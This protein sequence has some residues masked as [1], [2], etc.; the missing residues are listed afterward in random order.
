LYVAFK[1]FDPKNISSLKD[2]YLL[3]WTTTPWTLV[4]NQAVSVNPHFTYLL[5]QSQGK[6]YVI[7][8]DLQPKLVEELNWKN[9]QVLAT[10]KGSELEFLTYEHP[11]FKNPLPIINGEHVSNTEGSGLVHTAPGHG[12][13]DYQVGL[14][15]N[16]RV[17]CPVDGKG[18]YT[19]EARQYQGLFYEKANEI[20]INDLIKADLLVKQSKFTHSYPHDWRTKKPVI[21]RATPQWFCSI[22]GLKEQ[23]LKNIEE[24]KWYPAWGQIRMQNMIKDRSD[25]CI[26]RQRV[27]GV[28]LPIFYAEDGSPILDEQIILHISKKFKKYGSDC[29]FSKTPKQLLPKGYTHPASPHG[30]FTKETDIMDVW[31]DSG[32]SYMVVKNQGFFPANLYLEGADQFRGWFNSSLIT[33][34]SVYGIS[35]YRE[36]VTHGFV[37]DGAGRKMS[38]SLGN[39]IN[40]LDVINKYGADVLR[41][42]VSTTEYSVDVRISNDI[43]DQVAEIYRKIRNTL[44][45]LLGAINDFQVDKSFIAYSMQNSVNRYILERLD[46]VYTQ[47]LNAYE[48]YNFSDVLKILMPFI[49]NEL[50][51]FYLDYAKDILYI[52]NQF[53]FERVAL[54]SVLYKVTYTL[55]LLLN[56]LIPHTTSEAFKE[57]PDKIEEDIYLC[58]YFKVSSNPNLE[59]IDKMSIFFNLRSQVL[60]GLEE[61]RLAKIIGKSNEAQVVIN[62]P[63]ASIEVIKQLDLNLQQ[64]LIVAKVEIIED[65]KLHITITKAAG[66]VCDRC[67]N[68]VEKV[69]ENGLCSRCQNILFSAKEG[70]K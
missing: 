38:K 59:L 44:K 31:F 39:V 26:S 51:A 29:W 12:D 43:L 65:E 5:I 27:W 23:L 62:L 48:N 67:W 20:I 18:I 36:L 66:V 24:I 37:L 22:N 60:K 9:T 1:I 15:Y 10:F 63:K 68:T 35:P 41:L 4:A 46:L 21:Y 69:N 64:L 55:L 8:E 61:A 32:T 16:L 49:S 56:P 33:A 30:K 70:Q 11:L 34:T 17:F 3:I 45:Y 7:L 40:P 52:E 54:Q 53:N 13:D 42:W 2:A 14:K 57:F 50:S 25:W 19:K 58:R 28:P 6:K 47:C